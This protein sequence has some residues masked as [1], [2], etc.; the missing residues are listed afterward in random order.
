MTIWQIYNFGMAHVEDWRHNAGRCLDFSEA[1]A[2]GQS[3]KAQM[4]ACVNQWGYFNDPG[5]M[6]KY[7]GVNYCLDVAEGKAFEGAE[8]QWWKRF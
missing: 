2:N 8:V 6:H 1:T 4:W 7:N 3:A 5:I